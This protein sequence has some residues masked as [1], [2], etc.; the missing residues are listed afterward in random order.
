LY[1]FLTYACY[2]S[3]PSYPS[4]D[5]VN[6]IWWSV[7]VMKLRSQIA[8][9]SPY[10][11]SLTRKHNI[12]YIL[13][14]WA[15]FTIYPHTK[16]QH[17]IPTIT[18]TAKYLYRATAILFFHVLRKKKPNKSCISFADRLAHDVSEPHVVLVS[19]I[20][21]WRLHGRHVGTVDRNK[22]RSPKLG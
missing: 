17:I 9:P 14:T 15:I 10:L 20:P 1:A 11:K 3:H 4:F 5:H 8:P 22:L 6:N 21:I 2:M 18:R 13:C 19:F 7:Q 16:F 12:S